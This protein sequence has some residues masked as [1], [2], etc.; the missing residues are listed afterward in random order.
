MNVYSV[1]IKTSGDT[2]HAEYVTTKAPDALTA[3]SNCCGLAPAPNVEFTAELVSREV[4]Y[5]WGHYANPGHF[6]VQDVI[7]VTSS[8]DEAE[9]AWKKAKEENILANFRLTGGVDVKQVPA[10][11]P[12]GQIHEYIRQNCLDHTK[13]SYSV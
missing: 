8:A 13:R 3:I 1:E 5:A 12:L 4:W 9:K 2:A 11:V 7:A 10:S 6:S